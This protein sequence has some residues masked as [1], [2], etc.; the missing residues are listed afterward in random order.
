VTIKNTDDY[1]NYMKEQ[2]DVFSKRFV[3]LSGASRESENTKI[4]QRGSSLKTVG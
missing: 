3:L 4:I 2:E 1:Y